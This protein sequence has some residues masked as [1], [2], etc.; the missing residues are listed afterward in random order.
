MIPFD[1]HKESYT[2]MIAIILPLFFVNKGANIFESKIFENYFL[3]ILSD[4]VIN[5]FL[6][7]DICI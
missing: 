5:R 4:N 1:G 3:K 7:I 2:L 6:D